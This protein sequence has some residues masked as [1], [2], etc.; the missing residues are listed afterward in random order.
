[1]VHEVGVQRIVAGDQHPGGVLS[2]APRP[3]QLLPHRGA[4]AGEPGHQ[5][6]IEPGDVDA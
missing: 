3:A 6:R 4:G 1:M 2:T 5:D